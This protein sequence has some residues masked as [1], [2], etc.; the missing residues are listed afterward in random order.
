MLLV[1]VVD[2]SPS[3]GRPAMGDSGISRLDLAKMAVED[4]VRQWRKMRE[5]QS[6]LLGRSSPEKQR[7]LL[8][9]GQ[10]M[11]ATDQFWLLSTSSQHPEAAGAAAVHFS[12]NHHQQQP[13]DIL[14]QAQQQRRIEAFQRELKGLKV[15][16]SIDNTRNNENTTSEDVNYATGLNAALSA[17][18]QLFSRYRLQQS[19]TEN[20][21]MGR[22]PNCAVVTTNGSPASSAL[23][24]ASLILVRYLF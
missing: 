19:Q 11:N 23:Q 22:L 24:P 4:F 16:P 6:R 15:M 3:M 2:T 18:L 8:N 10:Y 12:D 21:G 1:F 9:L 17:G 7:L 20:F 5:N 14:V 13:S